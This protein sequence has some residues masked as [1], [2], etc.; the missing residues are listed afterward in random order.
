MIHRPV[1]SE[2]HAYL[3]GVCNKMNSP[4][5]KAGGYT[6]HVH[7]PGMLS[8]KIAL[9]K[10]MEQMKVHSSKWIKSKRKKL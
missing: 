3:G 2:P 1:E 10:L 7:I 9:M 8:K 5:F 4:A 6:D